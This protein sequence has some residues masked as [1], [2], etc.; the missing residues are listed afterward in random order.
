MSSNIFD[1][2]YVRWRTT[3]PHSTFGRPKS[4]SPFLRSSA[5]YIRFGCHGLGVHYHWNV[6]VKQPRRIPGTKFTYKAYVYVFYLLFYGYVVTPRCTRRLRNCGV[7]F[8]NVSFS[9][10]LLGCVHIRVN[11][12]TRTEENKM[13]SLLSYTIKYYMHILFSRDVNSYAVC[14]RRQRKSNIF[15]SV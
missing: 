4:R 7:I 6:R 14:L 10:F 3:M 2:L 11:E 1:R 12:Q 15:T 8:R 5:A 9:A 13:F